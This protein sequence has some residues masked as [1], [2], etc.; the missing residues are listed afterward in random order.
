MYPLYA[1]EGILYSVVYIH[2]QVVLPT[3]VYGVYSLVLCIY[4]LES[5]VF[6]QDIVTQLSLE[7]AVTLSLF[8]L[9]EQRKE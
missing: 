1:I 9:Q 3:R 5:V 2:Y 4:N 8:L 7:I 6:T